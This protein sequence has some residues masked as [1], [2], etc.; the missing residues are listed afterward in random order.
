VA[1]LAVDNATRHADASDITVTVTVDPD[2][3][4]LAITDDGRG[5]DPAAPGAVRVGARGLADANRRALAVG[6]TI[7]VESRAGGGTTV[8]FDW[9]A[10]RT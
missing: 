4:S 5:F 8:A 3:V 2:R 10:R 9:V 7:R 1:E 6:A